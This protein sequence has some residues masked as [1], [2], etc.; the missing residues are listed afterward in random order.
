MMDIFWMLLN[1]VVIDEKGCIGISLVL[2]GFIILLDKEVTATAK[3]LLNLL[4]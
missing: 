4:C 2:Y 1:Q 3:L